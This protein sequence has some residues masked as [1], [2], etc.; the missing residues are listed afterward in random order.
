MPVKSKS[1]WESGESPGAGGARRTAPAVEGSRRSDSRSRYSAEIDHGSTISRAIARRRELANV[2]LWLSQ[3]PRGR[4]PVPADC[5]R[6]SIPPPRDSCASRSRR[7][8]RTPTGRRNEAR[9][10]GPSR[11]AGD[12]RC[13]CEQQP[14][15]GARREHPIGSTQPRV[16]KSSTRARRCRPRPGPEPEADDRYACD[17][18][19]PA[20]SPCGSASS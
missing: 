19:N 4:H 9:C 7:S 18:L 15:L 6:W 20:S 12:R 8:R 11:Q 17:A 13:R 5:R 14:V 3:G 1:P 2:D 10:R 16:V